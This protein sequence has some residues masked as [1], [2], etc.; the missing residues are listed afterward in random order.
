[1]LSTAQVGVVGMPLAY[2]YSS[3]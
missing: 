2:A 3:L 1:M